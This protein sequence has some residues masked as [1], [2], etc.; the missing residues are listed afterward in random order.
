MFSWNKSLSMEDFLAMT[1]VGIAKSLSA[2]ELGK[3]SLNYKG[4]KVEVT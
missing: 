4:L 1:L 2:K 3:I